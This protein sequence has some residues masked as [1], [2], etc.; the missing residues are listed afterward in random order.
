[1]LEKAIFAAGCFWGV[2]YYMQQAPGVKNT[3]VGYIGGQTENPSYKEV[4]YENTGHF[5]AIEV[6]FDNEKISYEELA[7]LFFEIHDFTQTDGQGPDKGHQYLS[8]VFYFNDEQKQ[9]AQKLIR[10]LLDRNFKVATELL[11]A[12]TFW[13]AE[14]YH[15]SYYLKNGQTPYCHAKRKVF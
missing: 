9:I 1:M 2:E 15:Q 3:R 10:Q 14:D 8:V 4:C 6:T 13:P 12:T 11:P 5:E 7:K